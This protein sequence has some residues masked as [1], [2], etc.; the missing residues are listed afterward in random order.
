[1]NCTGT[2]LPNFQTY[3]FAF[4]TTPREE[5]LVRRAAVDSTVPYRAHAAP[6][7][8]CPCGQDLA[9]ITENAKAA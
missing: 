6:Q 5:A 7:D 9:Q 4:A 8:K 2:S 3:S 1:M